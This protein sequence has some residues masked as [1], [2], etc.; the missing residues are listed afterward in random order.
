[1]KRRYFLSTV[2]LALGATA[3]MAAFS[4]LRKAVGASGGSVKWGYTGQ[5]KPE[6]WGSLSAEYQVCSTGFQQSPI[7]LKQAIDSELSSLEIEYQKI[8]LNILNNGHTIKISVHSENTLTF[9]G[10]SF[11]LLEFHFHHPSEHKVAG[12]SYPM[13]IHLVHQSEAGEL[14]VL[15]IFL[16]EGQQ[17]LALKSIWDAMPAK[18]QPEKHISGAAIDLMQFLP[19]SRSTYRYFGSLTTPPCSEVIRW[20]VFDE[21]IEVSKAQIDRFEQIFPLN[22]RPVQ[23]LNHRFLLNQNK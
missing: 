2:S 10:T 7:D 18:E 14:A 11:K 1:M 23:P 15:G 17:N 21:A 6:N 12:K 3:T 22:A 8:P 19:A 16:K 13:E 5:E 20:I 4:N 9:D